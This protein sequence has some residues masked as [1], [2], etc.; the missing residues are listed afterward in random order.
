VGQAA[1]W[2]GEVVVLPEALTPEHLEAPGDVAQH[3]VADS[4]RIRR[5]LGWS[6]R[7]PREEALRRTVDWECEHPSSEDEA[8][9]GHY[10]A[11]DAALAALR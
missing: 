4:T 7:V 6:E 8:R 5:E 2:E 10:A 3:W 1:R 11:E 9:L